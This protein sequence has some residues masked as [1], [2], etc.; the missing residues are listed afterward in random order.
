[1]I[2]KLYDNC[3]ELIDG[4]N[5]E[6]IDDCGVNYIVDYHGVTSTYHAASSS[7]Q[8]Y[9]TINSNN[10]TKIGI[11]STNLIIIDFYNSLYFI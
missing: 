10:P 6:R 1:M 2:V 4:T 3:I 11:T 5:F 8:L 7:Y 9:I